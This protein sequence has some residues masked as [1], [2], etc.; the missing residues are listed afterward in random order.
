MSQATRSFKS[1]PLIALY[2]AIA[3][4]VAGG[5][6]AYGVMSTSVTLTVDGRSDSIRT[7]GGT[8]EDVLQARDLEVRPDDRLSLDPDHELRDGDEIDLAYA[9]PVT[10]SLDGE[11]SKHTVFDTTVGDAIDEIGV[12]LPAG[13]YVS[14]DAATALS[15]DANSLVISTNKDLVVAAD[16]EKKKITTAE[17]TVSGALEAA[18][19]KLGDDDEVEPGISAYL[20]PDQTIKVTRIETVTKTETAPV[21]FETKVERSGDKPRG[22][23]EVVKQGKAGKVEREVELVL[24]DGEVRDRTVLSSEVLRAPVAQ[25]ELHGTKAPEPVEPA[26][27]VGDGIWDRLAACESGGNWSINTGNGFYGGIQF[28]APTWASVG[29]SGL[30]HENSREEQ[31][32]RGKILQARAGWG[33]WPGCAAKLGLL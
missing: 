13:S 7:F 16:G 9:K 19:V 17:P 6:A 25:V 33:Q 31:I 15:R 5:T 11:I 28:S 22:E 32:K 29:G 8:V 26:P 24:A 12:D 3:L 2:V 27:A 10:L 14:Q 18:G 1:L 30:P 20:K 21:D 4:V 23:V